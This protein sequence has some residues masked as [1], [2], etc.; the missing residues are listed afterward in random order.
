[1]IFN[2]SDPINAILLLAAMLLLTYL[3]KET[4][5]SLIPQIV[6]FVSL[7]IIIIHAFQFV[8]M[9]GNANQ[10]IIQALSYSL[11][12]DFGFV[13]IAFLSYLWVDEIEAKVKQKKIINSGL[14]WFWRE[15]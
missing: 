12:I 2:T 14:D 8:T 7:A 13:F 5:K 15:V 3:G 9:S 6:L 10:E 11:A 1:M 4:K